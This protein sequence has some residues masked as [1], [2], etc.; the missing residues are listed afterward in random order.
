MSEAHYAIKKAVVKNLINNK[1][2]Y[3]KQL[4]QGNHKN[5]II[6]P[7]VVMKDIDVSNYIVSPALEISPNILKQEVNY[8]DI[9]LVD[10]HV[11]KLHPAAQ[12]YFFIRNHKNQQAE[13]NSQLKHPAFFLADYERNPTRHA[14]I[15]L[16]VSRYIANLR[17]PGEIYRT[18]RNLKRV[19]RIPDYDIIPDKNADKNKKVR[20][21]VD[22]EPVTAKTVVARVTV[23]SIKVLNLLSIHLL[24]ENSPFVKLSCGE[25]KYSTEVNSFGGSYSEWDDLNW[26]FRVYREDSLMVQVFSGTV[27]KSQQIGSYKISSHDF[28]SHTVNDENEM[29]LKATIKDEDSNDTSGTIEIDFIVEKGKEWDWYV[30][31]YNKE[32]TALKLRKKTIEKFSKYFHGSNPDEIDFPLHITI[33]IISLFDL[34]SVH[35][36]SKNKPYVEL[37]CGNFN[38]STPV[39]QNYHLD[40]CSWDDLS[41]NLTLVSINANLIFIAYSNDTMIGRFAIRGGDLVLLHRNHENNVDVMG[42]LTDSLGFSGKI[43]FTCTLNLPINITDES[44]SHSNYEDYTMKQ[45]A[46]SSILSIDSTFSSATNLFGYGF[47]KLPAEISVY[48]IEVFDLPNINILKANVPQVMLTCGDWSRTT[49]PVI[50]FESGTKAFWKDLNWSFPIHDKLTIELKVISDL[51]VISGRVIRAKELLRF[52]KDEYGRQIVLYSLHNGRKICGKI[53][54]VLTYSLE[55]NVYEVN[56]RFLAIAK[57]VENSQLLNGS[58]PMSADISIYND[59][60]ESI[61]NETLPFDQKSLLYLD[62]SHSLV[63]TDIAHPIKMIITDIVATDLK[64]VHFLVSNSPSIAVTCGQISIST[65]DIPSAGSSAIW[66]GLTSYAIFLVE[67]VVIKFAAWSRNKSIGSQTISASKIC[68]CSPNLEGNRE[69]FIQLLDSNEK[70]SGKLKLTFILENSNSFQQDT[71]DFDLHISKQVIEPPILLTM[72]TISAISIRSAH[73][74]AKNSL[75]VK[76]LC[77]TNNEKWQDSTTTKEHIGANAKWNNV[78]W[79][80]VLR[81]KSLLKLVVQSGTIV[82]GEKIFQI[83]EIMSQT[84]NNRGLCELEGFLT[85]KEGRMAD[86]GMVCISYAYESHPDIIEE[87]SDSEDEEN[88]EIIEVDPENPLAHIK[89][90]RDK[91]VIA[92]VTVLSIVLNN[93]ISVH[94]VSLNSPYVKIKCDVFR[95]FT[96]VCIKY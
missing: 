2:H 26:L 80:V 14:K 62:D 28:V 46:N 71:L 7:Q 18:Q 8:D 82:I 36:W 15:A 66:S 76:G 70:I 52:D 6:D 16:S 31:Q 57:S 24:E 86:V 4:N 41:W 22:W 53:K 20:F 45:S 50:G 51:K 72:F 39:H 56:K 21:L 12:T 69:L 59:A 81:D 61:L 5:S 87:P 1:K 63:G 11:S 89:S 60:I 42:D 95:A 23:L 9:S 91:K 37:S 67:N 27:T 48:R 47:I 88:N 29:T 25:F 74:F 58:L 77:M 83:E 33:S 55:G 93:L 94:T 85:D 68:D 64:S 75:V 17:K 65:S 30:N 84:H 73:K 34:K 79:E 19:Y 35:F 49:L 78:G 10:M 54:L 13:F 40:H 32:Q 44:Q 43:T 92:T 90:L 38:D 96:N 3:N